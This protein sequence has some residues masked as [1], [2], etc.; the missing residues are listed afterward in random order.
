MK[1]SGIYHFAYLYVIS[2]TFY[3]LSMLLFLPLS[4][5]IKYSNIVFLKLNYVEKFKFYILTSD[6][7]LILFTVQLH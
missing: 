2:V 3:H 4:G 1:L 6:V 7:I 5:R